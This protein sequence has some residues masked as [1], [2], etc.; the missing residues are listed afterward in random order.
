[1]VAGD[2]VNTA[3]RLQSVAQPGT[4]LVGEATYRATSNAISYEAAGERVL[5]GKTAP[6]PAWRAV[7]VVAR[8]GGSG[9]ASTL[10]PPFV[11]R[12]DELQQLKDLFDATGRERKPRL[13]TVIGQAGIGKCQA[14]LGVREVPRRGGRD[15][16]L[17][18]G[19]HAGVRGRDQLL[20]AGRDGAAAGADRRGRRRRHPPG[21][22]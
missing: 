19:P 22:S 15:G 13:V 2:L 20:G 14:R 1:M 11:G 5:K 3:S 12:E 9:R 18:R 7:A 17:A 21:R 4:V 16:V 10:E 8:R 6:V